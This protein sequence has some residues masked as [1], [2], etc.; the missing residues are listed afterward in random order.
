MGYGDGGGE[1]SRILPAKVE[2]RAFDFHA[3]RITVNS[4][5]SERA[6]IKNAIALLRT[7]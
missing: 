7:A 5:G 1:G 4:E 2:G 3:I 6:A